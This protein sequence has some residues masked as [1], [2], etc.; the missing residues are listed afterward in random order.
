M[1]CGL[2]ICLLL[3]AIRPW[4]VHRRPGKTPG[5]RCQTQQHAKREIVMDHQQLLDE[6]D[7]RN[8]SALDGRRPGA[9]RQAASKAA[10][11]P[12]ESA[13]TA[14]WI[15]VRLSKP[16]VSRPTAAPISEW[17]PRRSPATAWWRAAGCVHGRPVFVFAQDFTVL[18]GSLVPGPCREDL[19]GHGRGHE[20]GGPGNRALRLGRGPHPGRGDEPGRLQ[21]KSSCAT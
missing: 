4:A 10:S 6:L 3:L 16:T 19:Q 5:G 12:P 14:C 13:S 8:R 7:V 11:S 9:H 15:R 21:P 17:M 20:D 18:G 2:P 1:A